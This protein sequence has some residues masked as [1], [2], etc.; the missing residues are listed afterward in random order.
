MLS[1]RLIWQKKPSKYKYIFFQENAFENACC[2]TATIL[3]RPQHVKSCYLS[4]TTCCVCTLHCVERSYLLN[5]CNHMYYSWL[6][7]Q[8]NRNSVKY[9]WAAQGPMSLTGFQMQIIC[10]G[11]L[12]LISSKVSWTDHSAP[13]PCCCAMCKFCSGIITMNGIT[14]KKDTKICLYTIS[15][16]AQTV[17]E[18]ELLS[19]R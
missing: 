13:Q 18:G 14:A 16:L 8:S 12:I 4:Q 1:Y 3:P 6:Q 15:C 7:S 11:N 9:S 10:D 2:K 17:S 19:C 5:L